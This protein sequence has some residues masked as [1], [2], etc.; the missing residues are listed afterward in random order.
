MIDVFDIMAFAVLGVLVAVAVIIVVTL[1]QLPGAIAQKRGHPQVA[2]ITVAGWLGVLTLGVL[3]PLAFVWA[4]L[5][6][7]SPGQPAA[8]GR[9]EL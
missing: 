3:W 6:P 7:L 4:F 8:A 9:K 5:K 1:G 2:A